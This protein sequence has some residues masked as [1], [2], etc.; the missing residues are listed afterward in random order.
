LDRKKFWKQ[1]APPCCFSALHQWLPLQPEFISE[2][3][4]GKV[5]TVVWNN[6]RQ[7]SKKH[8]FQ[9]INYISCNELP[10]RN[11]FTPSITL[12]PPTARMKVMFLV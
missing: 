6:F 1:S 4:A 12:P 11:N 8:F 10:F 9:N 5:K 7:I 3:V 2:P